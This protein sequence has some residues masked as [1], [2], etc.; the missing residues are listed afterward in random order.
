M[1]V[2]PKRPC[3]FLGCPELIPIGQSYCDKHQK[4]RAEE[5]DRDRGTAKERGYDKNW[6]KIRHINLTRTPY[7]ERCNSK[8]L[9]RIA[10][11]VHHIDGN[12]RNNADENLMSLCK[13]C[14]EE[15]HHEAGERWR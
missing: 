1:P 12:S 7:C 9:I 13:H 2:K 14:H 11:M 15:I 6:R 3:G 8:G 4:K 5:Y 10:T